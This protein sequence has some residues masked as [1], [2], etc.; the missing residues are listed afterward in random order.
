MHCAANVGK[1]GDTALFFGLS[2]TGKTTLS[3]TPERI[4]IGDDEHGWDD[5]SVFNIEGG[6]YAKVINLEA[7]KE[8]EIYKAVRFGAVVE[9]VS[10]FRGTNTVDFSCKK[11]TEYTRVSYPIDYISNALQPSVGNI[12][13][14]IFFLTADAFGV[15]PPISKLSISQAMYFFISGYTAK[16]A[17]T[18]EGVIEPKPTFSACFGAP[19]LPLHPVVYAAM[20]EKKINEYQPCVWLI[21][22]GWTGGGYG[23]GKRMK[24]EYTRAMVKAALEGKLEKVSYRS[25]NLFGLM[26]PTSCPGVP[27]MVLDPELTWEN[28]ESYMDAANKLAGYFIRN[29]EKYSGFVSRE[30]IEA[31]PKIN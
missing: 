16:V 20:L 14:N 11:I 28:K 5:H 22:T 8:P 1:Q 7:A 17:G 6:C 27:S 26:T 29:F 15:L 2:G 13:A 30:I 9:N 21:N 31:G 3:A 19:F 18:E 4:L 12:P 25:H 24:L 10:F 23:V